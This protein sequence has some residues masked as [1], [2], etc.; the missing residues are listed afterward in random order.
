MTDIRP[1][2]GVLLVAAPMLAD[3]NFHR[4]GVLICEHTPDGIFGLIINRLLAA[5]TADVINGMATYDGALFLGGRGHTHTRHFRHTV[6]L[7]DGA[8][9]VLALGSWRG[10]FE[11]VQEIVQASYSGPL[12]RRFVLGFAGWGAGA[13]VA[14]IAGGGWFMTHAVAEDVFSHEH[15][16]FW[17][18]V[19]R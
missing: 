14:E 1:E 4:S 16:S 19:L 2:P 6:H 8:A 12:L 7:A 10:S 5:T 3:P 18:Q 9:H 15:G 11:G 17:R 13:V